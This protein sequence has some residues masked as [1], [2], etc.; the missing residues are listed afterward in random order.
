MDMKEQLKNAIVDAARR[1]I[2]DGVLPEADLP[3]IVLEVPPQKAVAP[4]P[5]KNF[6]D[7][8]AS[9]GNPRIKFPSLVYESR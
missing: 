4:S 2:A 6:S 8:D 3:Q 1:A 9:C 7:N 5:E